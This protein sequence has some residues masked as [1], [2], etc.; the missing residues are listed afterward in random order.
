MG[1]G[2]FWTP[3]RSVDEL[4]PRWGQPPSQFIELDGMQVHLRDEGPTDDPTPIVL[5]HGTGSSLHTWDG[6]AE[7]LRG[8]HRVV[9]FDRPGFGLTGPNPTGEYSMGYYTGFVARLLDRLGIRRV[10]LVGLSSGGCVAWHVA[11][12]SPDRVDRLVLIAASGY[13]REAPLSFG[14]R[15]AQSRIF[16]PLLSQILPRSLVESSVK[17]VYGDP[18]KVTP[19]IVDRNYEITL[20]AGNRAALGATLRQAQEGVDAPAI[21]RITVSTLIL[22]GDRDTVVPPA[23]AGR[24]HGDIP[25][26]EVVMF[27]GLGHLP[28]EEDPD[29]TT[30]AFQRFLGAGSR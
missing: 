7:R 27:P 23:H 20:R 3:D 18:G 19:E 12:A 2:S 29:A 8:E 5:I 30:A 16:G 4:K 11:L 25:G 6:W 28:N 1:I 13:P 14:F 10:I 21:R 24:F 17:N 15:L 9:R 26:S 22:W